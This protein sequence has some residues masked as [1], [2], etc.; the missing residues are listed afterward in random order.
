M[1]HDNLNP[2]QGEQYAEAPLT[3]EQRAMLEAMDSGFYKA[4]PNT[5]PIFDAARVLPE[6]EEWG[7]PH[8]PGDQTPLQDIQDS[9][10]GQQ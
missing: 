6:E 1:A 4:D 8:R 2:E 9:Y 7:L 5:H 3:P 10:E